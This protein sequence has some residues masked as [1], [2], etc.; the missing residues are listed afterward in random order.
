MTKRREQ[1][2]K[3]ATEWLIFTPDFKDSDLLAVLVTVA[4]P[5]LI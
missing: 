4:I 2:L 3:C 1:T 5:A